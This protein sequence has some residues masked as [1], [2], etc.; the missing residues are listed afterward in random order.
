MK[1]LKMTF[2]GTSSSK[3]TICL[4]G[5]THVLQRRAFVEDYDTKEHFVFFGS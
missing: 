4:P 2:Q 3:S 1:P 5:K